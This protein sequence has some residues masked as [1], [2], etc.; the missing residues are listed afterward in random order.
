MT[1][2]T[3]LTK[4][5][6][7]HQFSREIDHN[8]INRHAITIIEKLTEHNFDAYL[9]GGCVR[10]LLLNVAPKDF[11]IA[12]NAS[13]EEI[14]KVF[15]NSCRLIGR[16][17]RLAHI[18]FGRQIFEVATFRGAHKTQQDAQHHSRSDSGMILRDNIY[19]NLEE[20][21]WRRDFSINALYYDVINQTIIDYTGGLQDLQARQLRI[22]GDP[23]TRYQEDPVRMIRA[24]RFSA[25][26]DLSFVDDTI[27]PVLR[28]KVSLSEI[29]PSRLFEEVIKLLH[30][31]Q[32]EKTF[33]LLRKYHLLGQLFPLTEH[34]IT[35]DKT[36]KALSMITRALANTDNRVR[37]DKSVTPA[38]LCAVFLWYPLRQ[39]TKTIM[40]EGLTE[41][42]AQEIAMDDVIAQQLLSVSIPKRF[43]GMMREIWRLQ[44][45]FSRRHGK[46]AWQLLDQRR[47]RAAYD[48]LLIRAELNN[49]LAS[50]AD[51]WT[52]FQH[53]SDDEQV[54][55]IDDLPQHPSH[56]K[57][58]RETH[59]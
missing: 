23:L 13:P 10:D 38:F 3:K 29:S 7:T 26:L 54:T 9:V 39:R 12:T 27:E 24:L 41:L 33:H 31:G 6:E 37:A 57:P 25:K 51:W 16:R 1:K 11:D 59:E 55:M 42:Q 52:T 5:Q 17:F 45:R 36:D 44:H 21:A 53:L 48:F 18:R 34:Y 4:G 32:G 22:L 20:D 35:Q 15:R 46:R 30:M 19:G 43:T 50:L 8:R 49:D 28:Q 56:R 47:F 58:K 14:R 2:L 40:L